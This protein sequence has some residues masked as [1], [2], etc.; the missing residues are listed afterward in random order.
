MTS[1]IVGKGLA[2]D[3][4]R[5]A[6]RA[7]LRIAGLVLRP[8]AVNEEARRFATALCGI[9]IVVRARSRSA[10]RSAPAHRNRSRRAGHPR[11]PA[12]SRRQP[13]RTG[14][15]QS[16]RTRAGW[17]GTAR[18]RPGRGRNP[19]GRTSTCQPIEAKPSFGPSISRRPRISGRW[20]ATLWR[21]SSA[22]RSGSGRRP[23]AILADAVDAGDARP[24]P[25]IRASS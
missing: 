19:A 23:E 11:A 24:V 22:G 8:Q 5:L 14:R 7:I 6:R 20:T 17:S 25:M 3:A 16:A 13:T 2:L 12:P 18:H 1:A 21:R 10:T 4:A 15:R 9:G